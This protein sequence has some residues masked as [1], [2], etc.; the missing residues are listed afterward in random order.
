MKNFLLRLWSIFFYLLFG[1]F[2]ALI[3]PLHFLLLLS[4][5][6]WLH[7][8]SHF[9]NRV[10]GIVIMFPTGLWLF[11]EGRR[12]LRRKQVYIFTPN[13][14]SYLDIPICN[15]SIHHSF[16]FIGKAEL[17]SMPLFGYMFKRLHISVNRGSVTDSFKSF[18]VARRKLEEGRSILIF[19]EATIP[20]KKTVTLKKFKDGA[21]RM[22]IETG[23]PVVPVTILRADKALPD[24]GK[25]MIHPQGIHV[26]FH[27]PIPTTGMTVADAPALRD[28]VYQIIFDTLI[29]RGEGRGD[30][31]PD[32]GQQPTA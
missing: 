25:L 10:W 26:V 32:T 13:H 23:T 5:R 11:P 3:F 18:K 27:T 4:E 17:N 29:A 16:R 9:L 30:G 24:D 19:P 21:F 31:L 1:C 6:V 28:Q 22:A 7:D 8:I 20:D 14:T 2:F 15:V 12:Q